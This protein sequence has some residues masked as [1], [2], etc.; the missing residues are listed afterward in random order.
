MADERHA[1]FNVT[2]AL[3][4]DHCDQNGNIFG[5]VKHCFSQ[6]NSI[7]CKHAQVRKTYTF[8]K[9]AFLHCISL[10]NDEFNRKCSSKNKSLELW[11][12]YGVLRCKLRFF[13]L[14]LGFGE[15]VRAISSCSNRRRSAIHPFSLSNSLDDVDSRR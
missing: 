13:G 3:K 4:S 9:V 15:N 11:E 7:Q 1:F 6:K 2:H 5:F 12:D 14:E 10:G 8:L